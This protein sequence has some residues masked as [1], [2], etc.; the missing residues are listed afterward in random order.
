M[1]IDKFKLLVLLAFFSFLSPAITEAYFTT[2]QSATKLTD[3][4]I[5]FTVSYRFGFSD[6]EL[7]M[8]IMAIRDT[9]GST[10]QNTA[11]Y[12]IL[13]K[14]DQALRGGT[15]NAIVLT[16]LAK[17]EIRDDQYYLEP[18]EV[19]TFTL[20]ALL[21]IPAEEQP[22]EKWSLLMSHLPFTTIKDGKALFQH[23]NPSELQYYRT[24]EVRS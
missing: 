15:S 6:R 11:R 19:A 22:N 10:T 3:D 16:D 8:P 18:G 13:D 21:T 9:I 20:V 5:L 2:A 14:N 17:A 24:P 7:Y 1:K 12:T 23:L 4:T